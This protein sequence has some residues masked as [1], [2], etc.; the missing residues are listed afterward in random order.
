MHS[1][2][3]LFIQSSSFLLDKFVNK[4][5]TMG[6]SCAI[7]FGHAARSRKYQQPIYNTKGGIHLNRYYIAQRYF[8]HLPS[9]VT[10]RMSSQAAVLLHG[11]SAAIMAYGFNSLSSLQMDTWVNKQKG[12][13]FQFLT[14]HGCV[15]RLSVKIC[16]LN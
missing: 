8:L 11:S 4:A 5:P 14:V 15:Q 3:R 2:C 7:I 6:T 1:S 9:R 10:S 13:H 12:G 16:M